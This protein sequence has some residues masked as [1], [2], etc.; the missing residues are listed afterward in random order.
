MKS[1]LGAH[2]DDF[3]ISSRLFFKLDMSLERETTLHF[4][5]RVRR[6][7]P[8]MKRMRRRDNALILEEHDSEGR[9]DTQQWVRLE[10]NSFRFGNFA[11]VNTEQPRRFARF[12]LEQAPHHLTI[13]DLDIDHLEITY[14]F[15]MEYRG[16]HDQ[17][18]AETLFRD[19]PLAS[20]LMGD[21]SAH[22]VDCQ[23]YFGISL[24]PKCDV[25]AYLEVKS[26]TNSF[27]VRT[28]EYDSQLLSVNLSIHRYWGFEDTTDLPNIYER[29]TNTAS[30]LAVNRIVPLV[31]NPLALAIASRP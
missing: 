3:H 24:T 16:N 31:V 15:D 14:G 2:C 17:L 29:L 20:F 27:E 30:E 25:Q 11:P 26:R 19:H 23:P 1:I 12:L 7:Y 28:G 6:E 5:E 21:E 8:S 4:L 10:P 18:V 13:S 22:T 9:G